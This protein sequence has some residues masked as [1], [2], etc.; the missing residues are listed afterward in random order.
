M[1]HRNP[2]ACA[3]CPVRDRAACAS[4]DP[5]ERAEL[6]LI[7][8]HRHLERGE[9]LFEAGQA[10][11]ECA[12]LMSGAMKVSSVDSEGTER[13]LSL[14][15]PAGFAGEMFAATAHHDVV[16]LTECEVCVFPADRYLAALERFPALG[17]AVLRRSAEDLYDSRRLIDLM[18][19]R[20]AARRV[21][22][23]LLAIAEAASTSPCHPATMLDLPLS[24]AEIGGLLGL[25]IETVSRQL[26][27]L[28]ADGVICRHGPR[29][30]ELLDPARL[31][32]VAALS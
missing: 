22:A 28:Q 14:I 23:F 3:D 26:S 4:L 7:G 12:T 9:I 24:R 5:A 20:T 25:T 11:A 8:E 27:R 21:A 17:L 15:H 18:G 1:A 6:A 19:R 31:A 10:A 2:L 29:G 13:I 16:A 30:I 32:A